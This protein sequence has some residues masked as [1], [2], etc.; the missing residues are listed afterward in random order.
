MPKNTNSDKISGFSSAIYGP[1]MQAVLASSAQTPK[2]VAKTL[3]G[4]RNEF[5]QY[6][7]FNKELTPNLELSTKIANNV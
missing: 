5:P 1:N 6:A 4:K 7:I 3:V 2:L